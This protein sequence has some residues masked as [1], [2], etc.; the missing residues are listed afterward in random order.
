M[1]MDNVWM[2]SRSGHSKQMI[3]KVSMAKTDPIGERYKRKARGGIQ[4]HGQQL[5]DH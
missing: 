3:E 4:P 1:A 2:N 5:N